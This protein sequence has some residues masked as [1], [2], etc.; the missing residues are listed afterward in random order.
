MAEYLIKEMARKQGVTEQL[1]AVDM[2]RWIGLISEI[3]EICYGS[4][5]QRE[6]LL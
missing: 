6:N 1:K 4:F 5:Y 2:M 3:M